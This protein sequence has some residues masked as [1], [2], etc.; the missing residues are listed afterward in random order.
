MPKTK[1]ILY[2]TPKFVILSKIANLERTKKIVELLAPFYLALN[3]IGLIK[4][5]PQ[6]LFEL[7]WLIPKEV[8]LRNKFQFVTL[9][10][11]MIIGEVIFGYLIN[12]DLLWIIPKQ[13]MKVHGCKTR[14]RCVCLNFTPIWWIPWIEKP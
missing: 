8:L 3:V 12:Q 2:P 10:H 1:P 13:I 5:L 11:L 7:I 14:V 6:P 9:N 4:M